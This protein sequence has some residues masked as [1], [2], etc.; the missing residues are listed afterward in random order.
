MILGSQFVLALIVN[1]YQI[2]SG[3][4]HFF[5]VQKQDFSLFSVPSTIQNMVFL[6][7]FWKINIAKMTIII[8]AD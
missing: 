1:I 3:Q 4:K 6:F 2:R 8:M 7:C 5:K